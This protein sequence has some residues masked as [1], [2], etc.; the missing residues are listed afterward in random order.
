MKNQS[1]QAVPISADDELCRG[2]D[3]CVLACSLRHT[4]QCAPSLARLQ[5]TKDVERY[6]FTIRICQQCADAA[7]L[8]ACPIPGAMERDATGVVSIV[9]GECIACGRC[10]AACPYEGI[11]HHVGLDVYLKC[12]L[13]RGREGGPLCVELCPTGALSYRSRRE[14]NRE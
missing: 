8:E 14:A 12:D 11:A 6:H 5:V 1:A 9:E 2:C 10:M 4:A 3:M 7:C 13:C